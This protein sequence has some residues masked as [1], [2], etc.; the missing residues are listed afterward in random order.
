MLRLLLVVAF[1]RAMIQNPT[2]HRSTPQ[3]PKKARAACSVQL[4]AFADDSIRVRIAPPGVGIV[5]PPYSGLLPQPPAPARDRRLVQTE[6]SLRNGN[7]VI[8]YDPTTCYIT[9]TRLSDGVTLLQ[10]TGLAFGNP[11]ANGTRPGSVS[12]RLSLRG[13]QPGEA[14][15]GLG[16]HRTGH[17]NLLAATGAFY[18]LFQDTENY[19]VSRGGQASIPFYT[20]S[21]GYGFLWN[22]PSYGSVNISGDAITWFS[23]ATRNV[24]F[25]VTTTPADQAAAAGTDRGQA[26]AAAEADPLP[27]PADPA[28]SSPYAS[29]LRR[30]MDAVGHA[31][32]DGLPYYA[33]GF[34]QCKDRYRNQT[35]LLQV[36]REYVRRGLPISMLVVDWLHWREQGDWTFN[37]QCWPDPGAM[38][39]ELRDQLGIEPMVTTWGMLTQ[40][41]THYANFSSAA[42]LARLVSN[43][44]AV[45]F[46]IFGQYLYDATSPDARGALWAAWQAGYGR[47]GFRAVWL[48]TC[49][50]ERF[51]DTFGQWRY[52]GGTDAEV[53]EAWTQQHVAGFA[54]GFEAAAAAEAAAGLPRFSADYFLLPRHAWFGTWRHHAAIWSGDIDTTFE[55]F[56]LQ[57]RL[58]QGVGMSGQALWT[59]D[60][61]GYVGGGDP[62]ND[63]VWAELIVRWMQFAAFCPLFRLHGHRLGGPPPN[64]CGPTNGDNEI[65]TIA[66]APSHYNAIVTV[67]RLREQLRPYVA[68]VYAQAAVTGLPML[69]PMFLQWPGDG[70]VQAHAEELSDQYAFGPTWLV[71]P[72]LS[73]G[74][75]NR[76]VYL[77]VLPASAQQPQPPQPQQWVYWYDQSRVYAGGQSVVVDTPIDSFP[78]FFIQQ[79]TPP[80]ADG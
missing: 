80:I 40:P 10:Q 65:W 3:F 68:A 66:P 58:G 21:S 7:L 9:A 51:N 74:A 64:E 50:P 55:E 36:A 1:A 35:Q 70:Y 63:P 38:V 37:S 39:S 75:T 46:D 54:A 4:D 49:E 52:A 2:V 26:Q 44:T 67:M 79:V 31:A 76:S 33:T 71:A 77:P 19:S 56:A 24:D 30:Y 72:V 69:R 29:L 42:Y 43:D 41:S 5:E 16:Q 13:T 53:G 61:G 17:V 73:Y 23:N 20:S 32:A 48:D 14:V 59:T 34:I 12:A 18:S 15:Y 27:L 11:T 57:V 6:Q 25:W 8:A 45:P 78:L 22:S 60:A 62:D 28:L 47:Y